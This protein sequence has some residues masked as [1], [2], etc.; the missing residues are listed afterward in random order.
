MKV[1]ITGG[2]GFIGAQVTKKI[3]EQGN[4]AILLTRSKPKPDNELLLPG[5]P[6]FSMDMKKTARY[7]FN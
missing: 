5:Y 7:R 6:L 4:Q 3:I 1:L 2:T